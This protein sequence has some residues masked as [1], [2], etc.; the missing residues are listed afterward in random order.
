M[1]KYVL[2]GLIVCV[3]V[4]ADQAT[5]DAAQKSLASQ[6][7]S[8]THSIYIDVTDDESGL[9]M[10][11]WARERLGIE[12]DEPEEERALSA[13]YLSSEDDPNVRPRRLLPSSI[14]RGGDTLEVRYRVVNIVDGFW[15]HTY[16]RN[17]GA[18][19][20]FLAGTSKSFSRPFFLVISIVALLIILSLLRSVPKEN[21][22]LVTS[23]AFITGGA[24]GNLI[25]RVLYGYV[26]DF[27]EW[28]VTIGGDE[29][30]WPTFN[31]AD[32]FISSGVV[33]MII[34]M[35]FGKVEFLEPKPAADE[36]ATA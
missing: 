21:R 6:T 13:I 9:T 27:V 23:L 29:K 35:L 25:D 11:Q 28:Y 33:L 32:A 8:W 1:N 17:P 10:E 15:R 36:E 31:V 2:F 26:I 16:A 12:E 7:S 19:F 18:A 4:I 5:K 22:L 24:V 14:V 30:I 3:A 20:G 34:L